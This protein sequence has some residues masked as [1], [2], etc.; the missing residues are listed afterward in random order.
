ML[1]S[2]ANKTARKPVKLIH[3][4]K[5]TVEMRNPLLVAS[6]IAAFAFGAWAAQ[7]QIVS[8]SAQNR[9]IIKTDQVTY[10]FPRR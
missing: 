5:V 10:L 6:A 9:P 1:V 3:G 2:G 4:L 7:G 8:S